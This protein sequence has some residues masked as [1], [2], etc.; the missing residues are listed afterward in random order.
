MR[1]AAHFV[2]I[3]SRHHT[4]MS[5]LLH[6]SRSV[7][8]CQLS[9]HIYVFLFVFFGRLNSNSVKKILLVPHKM[10]LSTE[11]IATQFADSLDLK[12]I[13][14][15]ILGRCVDLCLVCGITDPE[16]FV[17]E[18]IAFAVSR[19]T[20]P[21]L[22]I[23]SLGELERKHLAKQ[24]AAVP[25]VAAVHQQQQH[26]AGISSPKVL[27]S[28][29]LGGGGVDINNEDVLMDAYIGGGGGGTTSKARSRI[30]E[31]A[32]SSVSSAGH[33]TG[34]LSASSGQVVYTFGS[35]ALLRT[36]A[37]WLQPPQN[38]VVKQLSIADET[39][40]DNETF[41][42]AEK[43]M[44]DSLHEKCLIA[45]DRLY[46]IGRQIYKRLHVEGA[47]DEP[48]VM[49]PNEA[50]PRII[51]SIGR[52]YND[53]DDTALDRRGVSLLAADERQWRS[54]RLNCEQ[55]PALSFALFPGQ[56]VCIEG[57]NPRGDLFFVKDVYAE[58]ELQRAAPPTLSK[59][60]SFVIAAG[61]YTS[62]TDLAYEPLREMLNYCKVNRP[63][64]LILVGPFFEATHRMLAELTEP[65]QVFFEKIVQLVMEN[66]GADVKVLMQSSALDAHSSM[67]YP[68]HPN[69][70]K[71]TY[72]NLTMLPDPCV[73][74]IN[75]IMV[76]VTGTDVLAHL[77]ESEYA[78]RAGE[79]VKRLV[80]YM[81]H[82][83][84]F[85]PI[86]PPMHDVCVDS[87]LQSRFGNLR[88]VPNMLIVPS[89]L[90][91]FAREIEG[92]L[93]V[94]SGRV[95]SRAERGTFARLIYGKSANDGGDLKAPVPLSNY[96]ACQVV[97]V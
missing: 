44:F 35:A 72:P 4:D 10:E 1:V 3:M 67:V 53:S 62:V 56:T 28:G 46:D 11:S 96:I 27:G 50:C 22:S 90:Q 78:L 88:T 16:E 21:T 58:R 83:A 18:W 43:Y 81:L 91:Y 19:P 70:L 42:T 24:K 26:L 71:R 2:C 59:P 66:V 95:T 94:N 76:A 17:D 77:A 6:V 84:S 51:R 52:I 49:H 74:D 34:T 75:G 14:P 12:N 63:D 93:V 73:V 64:V 13:S 54:V 92:C 41:T 89:D 29:F 47:E 97:K 79:R 15:A 7:A 86:H 45:C 85:Y 37:K 60:L 55:S 25:V 65:F 33:L 9:R 5:S 69:R 30:E 39:Y 57:L 87:G 61:P 38:V 20:E 31:T 40:K 68:T 48:E 82:Q 80:N 32:T 36:I 23:D 8:I